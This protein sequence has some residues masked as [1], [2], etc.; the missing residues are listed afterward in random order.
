M[1]TEIRL[2]NF[3]C[4]DDHTIPVHQCTI[5][6]GKN[7]AGK[8]T[9]VDALRL[10][11]IA[12]TRFL[13]LGMRPPPQWGGI[14]M[15][16]VG[17]GP[18]IEGMEFNTENLFH[19]YG[20]PPAIVTAAFASGSS[21]KIYIGPEGV[22]HAVLFD[23]SGAVVKTRARAR[24][25]G[26]PRVEIMPQVAPVEWNEAILSPEYVRRNL[27]SALAPRHFRNQL[28]LLQEHLPQFRQLAEETWPGLQVR[29]LSGQGV[30]T[31]KA[32]AL[33]VRNDD[34]VAEIATMG[35]GLQMWLQTMWFLARVEAGATV[36]L[37]EPDVYM[38]P[39]LQRRLVRYLRHNRRQ[40]VVTTHSVEIMSEVDPEDILVLD[41]QHPKSTFASSFPAAQRV[42]DHVGSAHNL[43]L[44][45]LWHAR[46]T[47]FVEGKDFRL[48]SDV[49]DVLYPDDQDGLAAIPYMSIGGWTGLPHAIGSS[50]LLRNSGGEKIAVYCILDSDYH[51]EGQKAAR[52][53]QAARAGVRLH[54]WYRKEIENYLLVP[55]AIL[56]AIEARIAKRTK[57][58]TL[59][60]V[61]GELDR[62]VDALRDET[63]D[64]ISNEVLLDDR[65][66]GPV[67][68]N[69][70][71][72]QFLE[73]R[74]K[75]RQSRLAVVSGKAVL[76]HVAR[77]SQDQ[78]G[79]SLSP[80]LLARSMRFPDVAAELRGVLEAIV[81][82]SPL[83]PAGENAVNYSLVRTPFGAAQFRR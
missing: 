63:F 29:E 62:V 33:L 64:G 21:L 46:R 45:R 18:S 26:V 48:L 22:I 44:A 55:A 65:K 50:L 52:R 17:V 23:A 54:I 32:L 34:Y 5:V 81:K 16:E 25:C 40:M 43:Q 76:T 13:T 68:A 35:H 79:V 82:A 70:K 14:P 80:S 7:N 2:Q 3:R 75:D 37:D 41:R 73:Q 24:E 47:L 69:K 74:W 72:R 39:D 49:F 9:L 10:V 42:L 8:S 66:L 27:S 60:E 56:R 61:D 36:I 53:E 77:W 71:A 15:R 28:N 58:P 31:G 78:F 38:H 1:L 11:S 4:F 51:T 30:A 57:P 67:G 59:V 19:R 12:S 20:D 83:P 6:V